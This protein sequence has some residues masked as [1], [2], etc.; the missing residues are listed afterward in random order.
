MCSRAYVKL[1]I[2]W[3]RCHLYYISFVYRHCYKSIA[4]R[5]LYLQGRRC[6]YYKARCPVQS[7]DLAKYIHKSMPV[8]RWWF[9]LLW[10]RRVNSIDRPI[11]HWLVWVNAISHFDE[12]TKTELNFCLLF[13]SAYV[14]YVQMTVK[15]CGDLY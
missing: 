1:R 2:K 10:L 14:T 12:I 11:N 3:M 7:W 9:R 13:I 6:I 15:C 8:V 4:T 5:F